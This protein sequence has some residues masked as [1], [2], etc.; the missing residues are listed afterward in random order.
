MVRTTKI[1][2]SE[3]GRT[4]RATRGEPQ[5]SRSSYH[6]SVGAS[7]GGGSDLM[8]ATNRQITAGC[9]APPNEGIPFGR[10]SA[11]ER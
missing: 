4:A 6:D 9:N 1:D 8:Y 2:R 3:S 11:I 10:P 7:F 5:T